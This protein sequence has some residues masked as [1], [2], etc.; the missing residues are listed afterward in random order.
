[1]A[2]SRGAEIPINPNV[3]KYGIGISWD[4]GSTAVDVDLQAVICDNRGVIIDAVYYNNLKALRSVT[5]SGDEQTGEKTGFDEIIWVNL[6]KLPEHV[7]VIVFVVAAHNRGHLRDVRNGLIHVV[8]D[9]KDNEVASYRMEQSPA[10][11]DAVLMMVKSDGG[12]WNL[13]VIDEPA[14][15][16]RHFIDIL[17]P[18]IGNL[19]R[20]VIPTAPKRQKIAFAMEKGAVVDLPATSRAGCITA[21]LGWDVSAGAEIDLDVSVVFF[22]KEGQNLGAVFFGNEEEFGVKHSGDN[23]TGEGHGDDETISVDLPS[24]PRHVDQMVFCVNIY[25][26][27]VSFDQVSNSYCRICDQEGMEMARYV[28]REGKGEAGLLMARLFREDGDQRWGFQAIGTF[29]RGQTWKDSVPQ[30]LPLVSTSARQ[31][32]MQQRTMSLSSASM[33]AAAAMPPAASS[34][35]PPVHVVAATVVQPPPA[36]SSKQDCCV[37]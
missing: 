18:T 33:S 6:K 27:G 1:M 2:L 34:A 14:R 16:G 20:A 7:K 36:N 4:A 5:H 23:L 9:T 15:E 35:Q 17:E 26:K 25:T 21:G 12:D 10:E 28:L 31:L 19:I 11:V 32:Q 24:I 3:E 29:C 8:E 13:R 30:M 37:Q 22:T